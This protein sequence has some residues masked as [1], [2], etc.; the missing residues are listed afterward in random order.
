MKKLMLLCLAAFGLAFSAFAGTVNLRKVTS[1]KVIKDGTVITG[2]LMQEKKISIAAGA[3]VTLRDAYI[4]ED[5]TFESHNCAGLTCLGDATIILEDENIVN[6]LTSDYPGIFVPQGSTL[7]IQGLGKLSVTGRGRAAGIGGGYDEDCGNIVIDGGFIEA[8]GGKDTEGGTIYGDDYIVVRPGGEYGGPAIG[9]ALRASCGKIS[10]KRGCVTARASN[11]Y[12]AIGAADANGS[13]G[14]VSFTKGIGRVYAIVRNAND[15]AGNPIKTINATDIKYAEGRQIS[16]DYNITLYEDNPQTTYTVGKV[17]AEEKVGYPGG[18]E[19]GSVDWNQYRTL[20]VVSG[21][22]GLNA[23]TTFDD[24]HYKV[25]GDEAV[26]Y[27]N[28]D[29]Y[30]SIFFKGLANGF[31]YLCPDLFYHYESRETYITGTLAGDY[32]IS[33]AKDSTV[34]LDEATI[35]PTLNTTM[36]GITCNGNATI[37]LKGK[38]YIQGCGDEWPGIFVPEGCKLTI[39]GDGTLTAVGGKYAPG[40]GSCSPSLRPVVIGNNISNYQKEGGDIEIQSGTITAVGGKYAS[41]L[42]GWF[43]WPFDSQTPSDFKYGGKVTILGGD[44][45]AQ[46]AI[47]LDTKREED[48]ETTGSVASDWPD[49]VDENV[50]HYFWSGVL[51]YLPVDY[52]TSV[53]ARDGITITGRLPYREVEE[54]EPGYYPTIIF[55]SIHIAKDAKVKFDSVSIRNLGRRNVPAVECDGNAEI[56]LV[57]HS[58]IDRSDGVREGI[59]IPP[60]CMLTIKGDGSLNVYGGEDSIAIGRDRGDSGGLTV[61]SGYVLASVPKGGTAIGARGKWS[62]EADG[63][64][65]CGPLVFNG[66]C[67]VAYSPT[68]DYDTTANSANRTIGCD[69]SGHT[70][71]M[72]SV[73]PD[74][75]QKSTVEHVLLDSG[76]YQDF[77]CETICFG[78]NLGIPGSAVPMMMAGAKPKLLGASLRSAPIEL[79]RVDAKFIA[80]DDTVITGTLLGRSKISIAPGATVTLRNAVIPGTHDSSSPFAGLT[81]MGDATIILEG[82]NEVSSFHEYFP[83]I[84]VPTNG[85]LVITGNGSLVAGKE[86]VSAAGAGIGGGYYTDCGNIIISNGTITAY[87]GSGCAGIGSGSGNSFGTISI[88]GGTVTASG[89]DGAAGIG[90]GYGGHGHGISIGSG[91]ARVIATAGGSNAEPIG[92]G[93]GGTLDTGIAEVSNRLNSPIS[94]NTQT[95]QWSGNLGNLV[96]SDI[97]D[98]VTAYDG[99]II[100][101]ILGDGCKTRVLIAPGAHVTLKGAKINR[102]GTLSADT[103]WAGLT[104]LGDATITIKNDSLVTENTVKAF[105]GNYPA[106]FVPGGSTLTLEGNGTLEASNLAGAGGAG[107]GGGST[108]DTKWCGKIVVNGGDVT[109][110]GGAL[111]SGIGGG[112]NGRCDGVVIGAGIQHVMANCGNQGNAKALGYGN[113]GNCNEVPQIASGIRETAFGTYF[114]EFRPNPDTDLSTVRADT[115]IATGAIVTGTLSGDHKISLAAG[116]EVT[117]NNVTIPGNSDSSCPWAGINCLGNATIWIEGENTIHGSYRYPGIHVPGGYTLTIKSK[118]GDGV[119]RAYAFDYAAGIG[120]GWT[121]SCGNIYIEGGIIYAEGGTQCAGIG[122]GTGGTGSGGITCGNL[123]IDGGTVTAKGGDGGCGIGAGTGS[124]CGNILISSDITYVEAIRGSAAAAPIGAANQYSSCNSIYIS[125]SLGETLSDDGS[126]RILYPNVDLASIA[127]GGDEVLARNGTT[128]SGTLGFNR[129]ITI[130]AGATVTI[131]NATINGVNSTSN[132]WA[133][134]TCLGD[135]TIILKGVNTVKGFYEEYPG[136]YVPQNRTLTIKGSGSLDVRSNGLGAGIGGGWEI[137]CGN[138]VI[139]GGTIAATGG[140]TAAAIGGGKDAACGDITISGG[141]VT[142]TGGGNASGIGAGYNANCGKITIDGTT[143][144]VVA[145]GGPERY[146]Y[147]EGSPIGLGA[148]NSSSCAG[149]TVGGSLVDVLDGQTRTVMNKTMDLAWLTSDFTLQNGMTASGTLGGNYKVSIAAGASVTLFGATIQGVNEG[150]YPWAGLTCLGDATVTLKGSNTIKGFL[151]EYPGIYVPTNCT[152]TIDGTGFLAAQSNGSAAGIGGGY[153]EETACGNIVIDGGTITAYGGSGS[154]GIGG[155]GGTACGDITI[156]GGTVTADGG[157]GAAGIGGGSEAACGT[158]TIGSGISIYGVTA[159]RGDALNSGHVGESIG[160]GSNRYGDASCVGVVVDSS[161]IDETEDPTRTIVRQQVVD[162]STLDR[163]LTIAKRAIL[164]G[165][166]ANK[167]TITANRNDSVITLRGVTINLPSDS[168]FKYPG[169]ICQTNVTIVLEGENYIVG[170]YY[171]SALHVKEGCTLTIKGSGSLRAVGRT[172]SAGIGAGQTSPYKTCGNIVIEGGNIKAEGGTGAPGI[173]SSRSYQYDTG[174]VGMA[175]SFGAPCGNITITGG[176][177]EAIAGGGINDYAAA[178]IGCGSGRCG[179]ITIGPDVTKI[180]ATWR[181]DNLVSPIGSAYNGGTCGTV[182]IALA[183]IEDEEVSADKTTRTYL[184]EWDGD[185]GKLNRAVNVH[186]GAVIFGTQ[187][188]DWVIRIDDG[189]EVM[190]DNATFTDGFTCLGDATVT[191]VGENKATIGVK[192]DYTLTIVGDGSLIAEGGGDWR[193]TAGIGGG[194]GNIEILGGTIIASSGGSAAGAA[195]IGSNPGANCGSITIGP[196]VKKVVATV[197]DTQ[198]YGRANPIGAPY[199][200]SCGTITVDPSLVNTNSADGLTCIITRAP[201]ADAI[202]AYEG[203]RGDQLTNGVAY[204]SGAW[205]DPDAKGVPNVMRYAFDKAADEDFDGSVVI[206]FATD[207]NGLVAIQTLPVV[208]GKGLFT[209]TIVASDNADGT[210]N[211]AEYPLSLESDG[212]TYIEEEYNPSRFFRVRVDLGQ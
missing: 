3:T 64:R 22:G 169:I 51:D 140:A 33:I 52:F 122:G 34:Y 24:H 201:G 47:H 162:L 61:E 156:N 180:V 74:M 168:N 207:G 113:N 102:N 145:V 174:T 155:G 175:T 111:A 63:F 73:G 31:A 118:N 121:L 2:T 154:A 126:S 38:N 117:L 53:V 72:L 106:I 194:C 185:L 176:T 160:R 79:E 66:G 29:S 109:A 32:K 115:E 110:S 87:G 187:N 30:V 81:C 103:P 172:Y 163:S 131:S 104:C 141:R 190:L 195:A 69:D 142:A 123:R 128:V 50:V 58:V 152:L 54:D 20:T 48:F 192:K 19:Y 205:N 86:N 78:G 147:G 188:E 136:I 10:F 138:I 70:R 108:D 200:E 62:N 84:S 159:R 181:S 85:T 42:G 146:G 202:A 97:K 68:G 65:K 83:A 12:P 26:E 35:G 27:E 89:R 184:P 100:Y 77:Q 14:T 46:G 129:K 44:I 40:I 13:C 208:N 151:D 41:G 94:G 91:V 75:V 153:A 17:F 5:W 16:K 96:H 179:D 55:P 15:N 120:G 1:N 107:I 101:G 199:T 165:T 206:D 95:I 132:M 82:E 193:G 196:N 125:P 189:A 133:G 171:C 116:A 80:G 166:L 56:T 130:A 183:D 92:K 76:L 124:S 90:T 135:A 7:T 36:P 197:A 149:I 21:I 43:K 25:T 212:I 105:N 150:E 11:N 203:W 167:Y 93:Y 178:A 112:N 148:G 119:L 71:S 57:G 60:D 182:D 173:G 45:T 161:L 28:N 191:L 211:V 127:G 49:H 59:A 4:N 88:V 67:T 18:K 164:T 198:Q 158:I 157:K 37:I 114:R 143:K 144:C 6:A 134:I 204:I 139:E 99:T 39:I 186:D 9:S 137:P 210:G 209:F 23:S 177:V 8:S 98:E 170:H